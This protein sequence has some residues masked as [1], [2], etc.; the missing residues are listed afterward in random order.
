MVSIKF[1]YSLMK[2]VMTSELEVSSDLSL[3][4]IK[5]RILKEGV[6]EG[7]ASY[8]ETKHIDIIDTKNGEVI[9]TDEQLKAYLGLPK[10]PKEE[11]LFEIKDRKRKVRVYRPKPR[12]ATTKGLQTVL[13][14]LRGCPQKSTPPSFS[15]FPRKMGNLQI[16][17]TWAY[18]DLQVS[19]FFSNILTKPEESDFR[20]QSLKP[21]LGSS[22]GKLKNCISFLTLTA[23]CG[24]RVKWLKSSGYFPRQEVLSSSPIASWS[25]DSSFKKSWLFRQALKAKYISFGVA[26]V[27]EAFFTYRIHNNNLSNGAVGKVAFP[28]IYTLFREKWTRISII[29][30]VWNGEKYL[31]RVIKNALAQ[32]YPNKEVIVVN[33]GSTDG[34]AA[35]IERFGSRIRSLYQP[36]QGLEAALEAGI[37]ASTGEYLIF[38]QLDGLG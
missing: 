20:R 10:T 7:I 19:H 30:P 31:E 35:I 27:S 37:H 4:A 24:L 11:G 26:Y 25:W 28:I 14:F 3:T 18:V 22:G 5:E 34:T 36:H 6:E 29:I 32:G 21:T 38:Y 2:M 1:Q 15:P 13:R 8:L 9:E 17:S 16:S 33:A 23:Q 12:V